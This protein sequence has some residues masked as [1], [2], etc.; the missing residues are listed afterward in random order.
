MDETKEIVVEVAG[1]DSK[2]YH[3]VAALDRAAKA[4]FGPLASKYTSRLSKNTIISESIP[5]GE[6]NKCIQAS[7]SFSVTALRDLGI[8]R[9][10]HASLNKQQNE[11]QI[12]DQQT[13][14]ASEHDLDLDQ[15]VNLTVEECTNNFQIFSPHCNVVFGK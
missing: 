15:F 14:D 4:T 5:T 9:H 11:Q 8:Q 3:L 6:R 12:P 1:V 2:D 7:S 10:F 13:N